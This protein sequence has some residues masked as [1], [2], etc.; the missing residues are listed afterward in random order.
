M[1]QDY[2]NLTKS[3]GY[4]EKQRSNQNNYWLLET[5][6]QELTSNFYTKKEVKE[7]LKKYAEDIKNLKTTPFKAA[8]ELLK[9][10]K[11]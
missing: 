10:S 6:N 11:K 3:N 9:L 1:I 8:R 7:G 2:F 4:F 5:I